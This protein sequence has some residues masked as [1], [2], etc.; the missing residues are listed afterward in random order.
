MRC[1]AKYKRTSCHQKVIH[2]LRY[3][4][5]AY[6]HVCMQLLLYVRTTCTVFHRPSDSGDIEVYPRYMNHQLY[7]TRMVV[8]S[9]YLGRLLYTHE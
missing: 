4:D 2:L 3:Y 7:C 8:N 6:T 9:I 1:C 5:K